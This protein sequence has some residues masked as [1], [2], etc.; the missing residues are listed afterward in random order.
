MRVEQPLISVALCTF[1]GEQYIAEQLKTILGQ[2]YRNLEIII[3]DDNSQDETVS[4]LSEYAALDNR[5]KLFINETNLGF[6]K[7]F[8]KALSLTSG[9]FI[10]ISDQDDIWLPEKI[11]KLWK[12]I[13]DD[14]LIFS[15]SGF[16]G[17]AEG[18][19]LPGFKLPGDYKGILL[20]NFVTGHTVL[21]CRELLQFVLPVPETGYYDWWFGFVASYHHKIA[22]LPEKLTL[23][24]IHTS[25]VMWK[26]DKGVDS[27]W[28]RYRDISAMLT[29]FSQYKALKPADK[30]FITQLRDAYRLKGSKPVSIPLINMVTR[31]YDAL[32]PNIRPRKGFSRLNFAFKYSKGPIRKL[33]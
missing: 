26:V 29:A 17:D 16:I 23:H 30:T 18:E 5:I 28:K 15:N 6:N 11:S 12:N 8:E 27:K 24:R 4:I 20:H 21:M 32:F 13:A 31:Y 2:D 25:S 33:F 14:W 7:N 10:A 22:C 3:V 9:D 19:L 1:N